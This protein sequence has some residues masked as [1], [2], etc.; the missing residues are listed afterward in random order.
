MHN[1]SLETMEAIRTYDGLPFLGPITLIRATDAVYIPGAEPG[2]G[3][4]ALA[5]K[6]INVVW[7]PGTH[8]SM[9]IEPNLQVVGDIVRNSLEKALSVNS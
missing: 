1:V 9:F 5:S 3:W 2:C 4:G 8:E 6:G 7:A